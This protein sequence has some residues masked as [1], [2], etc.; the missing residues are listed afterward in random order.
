MSTCKSDHFLITDRTLVHCKLQAGSSTS[1]LWV[2]EKKW[3]LHIG[4]FYSS[5]KLT[6]SSRTH[7][8]ELFLLQPSPAGIRLSQ[9]F[10]E[11]NGSTRIFNRLW[12]RTDGG[13][14]RQHSGMEVKKTICVQY[15][16]P[17]PIQQLFE[18]S[19]SSQLSPIFLFFFLSE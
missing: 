16:H 10:Q 1:Q 14:R 4:C 7:Y 17:L 15:Q 13:A 5:Q 12:V 19:H 9:A 11:R 8:T 3:F 6:E 18:Q 2:W